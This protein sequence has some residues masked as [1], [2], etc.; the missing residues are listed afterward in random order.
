MFS[1]TE[2]LFLLVIFGI[3]AWLIRTRRARQRRGMKRC[4]ECG[5]RLPAE[6]AFCLRCGRPVNDAVAR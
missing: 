6:A 3:V 2:I 1:L 4:Y 5:A